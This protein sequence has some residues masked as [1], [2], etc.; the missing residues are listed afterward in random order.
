MNKKA[1]Q[2]NNEYARIED[3]TKEHYLKNKDLEFI[4]IE[5]IINSFKKFILVDPQ[6][7]YISP[8]DVNV[9]SINGKI[10]AEYTIQRLK[11]M[12]KKHP[13]VKDIEVDVIRENVQDYYIFEQNDNGS[14][15]KSKPIPMSLKFDNK[16]KIIG[17]FSVIYFK[18]GRSKASYIDQFELDNAKKASNDSSKNSAWV[19]FPVEMSKKVS[20]RRL[21]KDIQELFDNDDF[22]GLKNVINDENSNFIFETKAK[23]QYSSKRITQILKE[24]NIDFKQEKEL[25]VI[26]DIDN[27]DIINILKSNDF[28]FI[29]NEKKW[30]KGVTKKSH[31]KFK[32][33]ISSNNALPE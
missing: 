10:T 16:S 7:K 19:K 12:I 15:I 31:D 4:P 8:S 33:K 28:I 5:A 25:Y 26:D 3:A 20:F 18:D 1:M 2:V 6:L 13:S 21:I 14:I 22:K 30:K 9:Y 27:E 24:E 23:P 17:A 11:A 29:E 32:N